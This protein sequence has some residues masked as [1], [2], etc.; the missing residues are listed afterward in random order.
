MAR[1]QCYP[2]SPRF[3]VFSN[4]PRAYGARLADALLRSAVYHH[5]RHVEYPGGTLDLQLFPRNGYVHNHT[6]HHSDTHNQLNP[7][8]HVIANDN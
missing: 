1:D 3:A 7:H 5:R 4:A 8:D 2:F 6:D